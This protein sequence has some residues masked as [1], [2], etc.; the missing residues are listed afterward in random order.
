MITHCD[1]T[2]ALGIA[3][4]GR[5]RSVSPG[6][7][8][9]LDLLRWYEGAVVKVVMGIEKF[10]ADGLEGVAVHLRIGHD[11]GQGGVENEMIKDI[12]RLGVDIGQYRGQ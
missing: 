7:R 12:H 2:G 3:T 4:A 6:G 8:V 11:V 10:V 5:Q 9:G 1:G